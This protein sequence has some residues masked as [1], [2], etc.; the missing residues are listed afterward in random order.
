MNRDAKESL[1]ALVVVASFVGLSCFSLRLIPDDLE[2]PQW[3]PLVALPLNLLILVAG[4]VRHRR[5]PRG[6]PEQ[7]Y[8]WAWGCFSWGA[9][10][11]G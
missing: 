6:K 5:K 1:T 11:C 8:A 3:V 2:I 7:C 4:I 9:L 10:R